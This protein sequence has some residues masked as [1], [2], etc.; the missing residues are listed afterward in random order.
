MLEVELPDKSNENRGHP[1]QFELLITDIL[2]FF[3]IKY[4]PYSI[5]TKKVSFI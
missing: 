5:Y 2:Y 1:V 3:S 4:S